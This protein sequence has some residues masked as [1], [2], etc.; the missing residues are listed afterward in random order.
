MNRTDRLLALVLELRGRERARAGDL[1]RHF[2]VGVRTIYR[3]LSALGEAGVPV[4]GTPGQGYQLL[5][6][7]FL[8]PLHLRPEEAVM[9]AYGLDG[10]RGAF[11]AEYA[12][13]AAAASRKLELALT[14][15]LRAQVRH[16]RDHIR[17]VGEAAGQDAR[18]GLLRAAILRRQRLHFDYHKPGGGPAQPR[19]AD[20]LGLARVNGVWLLLAH[21]HDRN[22][23]RTFRLERIENA[24]PSGETFERPSGL[25][26]RPDPAA[27][28]RAIGVR[29]RFAPEHARWVRE[30][31]SFFQTQVHDG[32]DGH[33][34]TL[35]VRQL[36][37]VLPWVLSW[38]ARV[39]V[40]APPE[41]LERVRAEAQAMLAAGEA[42]GAG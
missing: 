11:D 16:L 26:F 37:D 12:A 25:E 10:V 2:G 35:Q 15:E 29:L 33:T 30:R 23:G 32:P 14:P 3:D 38:G 41:L 40:L 28:R 36:D 6:G 18:L 5:P 42:D 31:P 34:I 22:A 39:Q 20:P 21:D 9:L 24:R 8:P 4:V 1:A 7:Y 27:E 19:R 13:A 17:L